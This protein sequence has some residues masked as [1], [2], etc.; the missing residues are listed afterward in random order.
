MIK[1]QQIVTKEIQQ[2]YADFTQVTKVKLGKAHVMCGTTLCNLM[3][4]IH[5]L[6]KITA[7]QKSGFI[8]CQG[9]TIDQEA[10]NKTVGKKI[11]THTTTECSAWG[12]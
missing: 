11:S 9:I 8:F 10:A 1:A 2:R 6:A 12:T 4:N 5:Y 7:N 3:R